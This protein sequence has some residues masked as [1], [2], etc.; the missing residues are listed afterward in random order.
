VYWLT[1][2]S[3][4]TRVTRLDAHSLRVEQARGFLLRPEETHYRADVSTLP[5][6]ASVTLSELQARVVHVLPDGRP[7]R[8]D[9]TFNDP[10]ESARY[11]FRIYR[12]GALLPWQMPAPGGSVQ[13]PAQD[14]FQLVASEV[15]R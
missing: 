13:L 8:V 14:F 10:L 9:F 7:Q 6:S 3:S 15:L 5:A 12:D 1:S 11:L 2:S 4:E